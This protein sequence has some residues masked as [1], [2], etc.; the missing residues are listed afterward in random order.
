M[1]HY[2]GQLVMEDAL[3]RCCLQCRLA[4]TEVD[5]DDLTLWMLVGWQICQYSI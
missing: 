2:I 1:G 3:V 4:W 5:A